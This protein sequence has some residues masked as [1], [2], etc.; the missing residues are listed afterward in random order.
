MTLQ[1]ASLT[2]AGARRQSTPTDH[3]SRNS[4]HL[5]DRLMNKPGGLLVRS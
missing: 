5:C 1:I 2:L 3:L 4:D